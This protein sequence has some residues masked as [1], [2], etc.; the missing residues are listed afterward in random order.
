[1]TNFM[2]WFRRSNGN[3]TSSRRYLYGPKR[4]ADTYTTNFSVNTEGSHVSISWEGDASDGDMS[5]VIDGNLLKRDKGY[6]S[7][8]PTNSDMTMVDDDTVVFVTSYD[9]VTYIEEIRLLDNDSYRLRQTVA[10]REET[11]SVIIVG[12]YFEERV[13]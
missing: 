2:K 11:N 4:K 10:T 3:W 5:M 1:M 9:G 6:F 12:Q 8:A 7:D 13:D